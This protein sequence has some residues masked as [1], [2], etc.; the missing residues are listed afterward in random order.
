MGDKK[1]NRKEAQAL[2]REQNATAL[3]TAP[4]Y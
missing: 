3:K 2:D 1:I 4:R